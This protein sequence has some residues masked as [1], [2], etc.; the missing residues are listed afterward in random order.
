M[1]PMT[2]AMRDEAAVWH[3]FTQMKTADLAIPIVRGEGVWLYDEQGEAYLDGIASWWMNSHGHGNKYIAE[4]IAEQARTLEHVIF[5]NFTHPKAVELAER[6]LEILPDNQDKIFYS[7]NGSTSVE[8][9]LKMCFQYWY[10]KGEQRT[11]LLAFE[12]SYHGDTFGAMSAGSRSAF[13]NPFSPFL[14]DVVFID[15]PE[16]GMEEESLRQLQAE[17]DKGDV[18]GFIFEPLIQGAG[19]MRMHTPEAL[20]PL[21]SYCN[22]NGVITIADEVMVAW[23]KCGSYFATD[24]IQSVKPDIYCMSK[25]LTGGTMALGAT[26]CTR[27]IYDA[28]YDDDTMKALFH[29][30]SCTGNPIACACAL[31]S[32]DLFAKPETW[33]Q[34]NM[35][36]RQHEAFQ[37]RL[38]AFEKTGENPGGVIEHIRQTGIVLAFDVVDTNPGYFSDLRSRIWHHFLDRK[39]ILRPLGN[40]VYVLPPLVISSEELGVIYSAIEELVGGL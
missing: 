25:G 26:S 8:V 5:A 33:D 37:Q 6:L 19:G 12:H 22:A 34:V 29:G 10:N 3:P 15:P 35:I 31:A 18:A 28:F 24:F 14:F 32:M 36:M 1:K 30:H 4:K 17:V 20:E 27:A 23:G 40:T 13:S 2:L 38:S 9:G 7:D 11:R 39:I 16:A 21:L